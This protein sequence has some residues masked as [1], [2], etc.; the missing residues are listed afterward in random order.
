M[1][2]NW[3]E[4][5]DV[6]LLINGEAFFPRVFDCLKNA[7]T[8]ILLE[9]FIIFSD[10]VGL[11]LKDALLEAAA[12]GVHIEVTVDGY[13]TAD[14]PSEYIAELAEAGIHMHMFDPR[15]R[16]LG[17][18]TNLFRRLHRKIIV[19]D[20][21]TAFIGGIN[22]GADHLADYGPMAKQDYAVQ[23]RGPIVADIHKASRAILVHSPTVA[24]LP[25]VRPVTR[26][27]GNVRMLLTVRDNAQHRTDIEEQYIRAIRSA[28]Y[29]LVIA[30][31]YFFPGYRLLRE[32]RN[33]ARRGV[34]VTLILQGQP[35]MPWARLCSSLLYNYLLREGVNICEYSRRPLHG[36]VALADREWC[37]VGSSNLD[38]LSLSLNLEANLIIRDATL[39]QR[40]YD[41]LHQLADAQCES[42]TPKIAARGYWWRAPLIFASFHF[43][44]HFP[45]IIGWLPAHTPKLKPLT[46]DEQ[47]ETVEL[48]CSQEK[49]Q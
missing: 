35:D 39:N 45:A 49:Q 34:K 41:H 25:N 18:R 40:L 9:T 15:P 3:Q 22:F 29:R 46:L 12:R 30:N 27:V 13:G 17:M 24:N 1:K 38:P 6:E 4:G 32:L 16:M 47:E 14:L 5:N 23:V 2:Y 26:H 36:K 7:R 11:A 31:A 28:S 10:K 37:T 44:R 42:I 20:G 33:A 48:Q 43:L 8:E 21:E 19:I